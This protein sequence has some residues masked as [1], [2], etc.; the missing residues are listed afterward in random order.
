MVNDSEQH[1]GSFGDLTDFD[2]YPGAAGAG[3]PFF[4]LNADVA[5][6][7]FEAAG[8]DYT[9]TQRTINEDLRPLNFEFPESLEVSIPVGRSA[10]NEDGPECD[11]VDSRNNRRVCRCRRAL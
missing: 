3:I 1:G 4:H 7:W 9:E 8:K 11:G 10:E 6:K 2:E 5:D